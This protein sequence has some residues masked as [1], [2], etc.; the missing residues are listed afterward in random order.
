MRESVARL[1]GDA[2]SAARVDGVAETMNFHD[3]V[4]W[5]SGNTLLAL[6]LSAVNHLYQRSAVL[7]D[8]P[9]VRTRRVAKHHEEILEAIESGDSDAAAA[10]MAAHLEAHNRFLKKEYPQLLHTK[11]RWELARY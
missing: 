4:A 7:I 8:F 6:V 1:E 3:L 11:V 2:E 5:A 9:P 10:S